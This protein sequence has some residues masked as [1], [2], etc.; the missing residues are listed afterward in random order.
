MLYSNCRS[1]QH[2]PYLLSFVI[3]KLF[4]CERFLPMFWCFFGFQCC[5]ESGASFSVHALTFMMKIGDWYYYRQQ[6]KYQHCDKV[7]MFSLVCLLIKLS[8]RAI[9]M[10][11]RSKQ[12]RAHHTAFV[13]FNLIELHTTNGNLS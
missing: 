11:K 1:T 3:Y 12:S 4:E 2:F 5:Q 6:I 9:V 13:R 10:A 7:C 8:F